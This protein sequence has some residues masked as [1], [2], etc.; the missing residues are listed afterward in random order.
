MRNRG[1]G[2]TGG[3]GTRV[4]GRHPIAPRNDLALTTMP[5]PPAPP[6]GST[7]RA[8][9]WRCRR[10]GRFRR[11]RAIHPHTALPHPRPPEQSRTRSSALPGPRN[12]ESPGAEPRSPHLSGFQSVRL[13]KHSPTDVRTWDWS[14]GAGIP[15]LISIVADRAR[16]TG[17]Y[18]VPGLT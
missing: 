17:A 11:A 10:F 8:S 3:I 4:T 6:P 16:D 9:A 7:Q 5:G 1:T 2:M 12:A 18:P 13:Q 14:P 15:A